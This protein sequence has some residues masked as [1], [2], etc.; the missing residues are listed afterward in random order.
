MKREDRFSP[1]ATGGISLLAAFAVL[2]LTVFAL[3]C[4]STV[5]ANAR[6][7]DASL[8]AVADYYMADGQALEILAALKRGETPDGVTLN[9]GI[10]SY[11]CPVS[12]TQ[13]LEV[14][15]RILETGCDILRWQAVP[16]GGDTQE[17]GLKLWDGGGLF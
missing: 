17:S 16:D 7:T 9:N 1:P 6:L 3:L 14:E 4:L 10:Y 15:V 2:C 13:V 11:A 12:E 5:Q 8:R